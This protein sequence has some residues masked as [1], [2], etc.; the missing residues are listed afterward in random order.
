LGWRCGLGH[1]IRV[2]ASLP[3]RPAE[4]KENWQM[5]SRGEHRSA[6]KPVRAVA[7]VRRELDAAS[8]ADISGSSSGAA[9]RMGRVNQ[10]VFHAP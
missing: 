9:N 7:D 4:R 6:R 10:R 1:G 5:A 2:G 8:Y 3:G